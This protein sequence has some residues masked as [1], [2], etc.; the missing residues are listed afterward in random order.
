MME[1]LKIKEE[2]YLDKEYK[3]YLIKYVIDD[4][5]DDTEDDSDSD[6]I[7]SSKIYFDLDIKY[8]IIYLQ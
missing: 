1:D 2:K 7:P 4:E 6:Y 8:P 5:P 3:N